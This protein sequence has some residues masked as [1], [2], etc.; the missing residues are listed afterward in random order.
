M[1]DSF[2]ENEVRRYQ[3]E[4]WSA[5]T[6]RVRRVGVLRSAD[7]WL[8]AGNTLFRGHANADWQLQSPLQRNVARALKNGVLGQRE[9]PDL[10]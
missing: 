2:P 10:D 6:D 1:S 3:C 7:R 9:N 5:F 4:S 8:F